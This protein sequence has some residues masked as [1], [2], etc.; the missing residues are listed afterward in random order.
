MRC[1]AT[2]KSVVNKKKCQLVTNADIKFSIEFFNSLSSSPTNCK[3]ALVTGN[4]C[5]T[6][7]PKSAFS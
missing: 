7:S 1:Y 6:I 3:S 4:V 2:R 5:V